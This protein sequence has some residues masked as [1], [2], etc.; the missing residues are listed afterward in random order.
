MILE[1]LCAFMQKPEEGSISHR[2]QRLAKYRFLKKQYDLLL[3][4]DDLDAMWVCLR[5]NC[6][7]DDATGLGIVNASENSSNKPEKTVK[8]VNFHRFLLGCSYLGTCFH[9]VIED[10]V[11]IIKTLGTDSSAHTIGVSHCSTISN[12]LYNF[13]GKLDQD[14]AL[15]TARPLILVTITKL[16]RE[17]AYSL[18]IL[19]CWST[20]LQS[21]VNQLLQGSLRKF[22]AQIAMP[23]EKM[24]RI[25]V[26][27]GTQGETRKQCALGAL[28]HK[29]AY[30]V[31]V[32]L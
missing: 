32:F 17:E 2:V 7:I 20:V 13:T 19:S 12:C 1:N 10:V 4:A 14:P 9:Y 18:Q 23:M 24:E 31:G 22:Y 26:K 6:V 11:S 30:G 27:T 3:N 28:F 21:L 5:E 29:R 16:L 25:N 8:S 15:D